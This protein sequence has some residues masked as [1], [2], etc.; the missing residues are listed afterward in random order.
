M[1]I[2]AERSWAKGR[3]DC[4]KHKSTVLSGNPWNDPLERDLFV[5]LPPGYVE[6]ESYPVFWDL[7]AYTNSG[8]GHV[9]WRNH[10]ENIPQRLDRLIAAEQMG[11][12]IA[13]FPDCYTSLGGNQYLNSSGVGRYEDYL[14]AELMPLVETRY[15]V[16]AD[17]AGRAIFGKSSGAYGA[18]MQAIRHPEI[19][20][21]AACH[22]GDLNFDL[23]YRSDFPTTCNVLARHK[24]DVL[25]F[26]RHFWRSKQP[27][28]ADFHTMMTLCMAATYDPVAPESTEHGLP[29]RLPFDL[30]TCELDPDLWS[31]WLQFDPVE[32]PAGT[33]Q[34]LTALKGLYL[35]VGYRDQY[36]IHFGSRR[37]HRRLNE[38]EIP[39]HYEE[40]DGTHSGIDHRLDVSLPWLYAKIME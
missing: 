17:A 36:N 14:L 34:S 28:G 6:N 30:E 10:G 15:S 13:V 16:L 31:R 38:L 2:R 33:L 5:Y 25:R 7:A 11:P 3:L 18:L 39:H 19:W 27:G 22:S 35:D 20:G 26:M 32:M 37:F 1:Q 24:Y 8:P 21:A 9:N 12:V 23:V 4:I 40:F 29:L